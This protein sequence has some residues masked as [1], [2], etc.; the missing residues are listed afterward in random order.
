MRT[1]AARSV[2]FVVIALGLGFLLIGIVGVVVLRTTG[3]G[4][5]GLSGATNRLEDWIGSQVVGIANSYL[6]PQIGYDALN[7]QA[8]GTVVLTGVTFTAPDGTEVL[9]LGV[10]TVTLAEVPRIGEPIHIERLMLD[11]PTIRLIR[12]VGDDGE[13]GLRGLNPI[14]KA[15]GDETTG[16]AAIEDNFKLS[17]VLRLQQIDL[18]E[19]AL[20]YDQGDGSPPMTISGL[21]TT[22]HAHA[23]ETL[24]G[25]YVLDVESALGP[26]AAMTL[27]GLVSLDTF[28]ARINEFTLS[29]HLS[30]ESLGILP[31]QL[32]TL[33][34][35]YEV[36]GQL[37]L[38][39]SGEV[40]LTDSLIAV[41]E[42]S[43]DLEDFR[44]A[45]GEYQ[46]PIQS[47]RAEASLA[48]GVATLSKL[49]ATMLGGEVRL[50]GEV[51]LAETGM[52]ASA[53]WVI[54]DIELHD[55]LR[56]NTQTEGPPKLAGKL[57]AHGRLTT[58]LDDPRGALEGTGELHLRE[59][60]VMVLPGLTQLASVM[61]VIT[62]A[63][64][65]EEALNHMADAE[66]V[67]GPAG[68]EITSSE[69][70]TEFLVARGTGTIGFDGS[71][72]LTINGGP[73]E[74][75]QS[76]LGGL[77]DVIGSVTDRLVKYRIRGTV[78]APEVSVAPLGI[79]G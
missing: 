43:M 18:I 16:E 64:T 58:E 20:F 15:P 72:D 25:W 9:E 52:P 28:S 79:G 48:G 51:R 74:K 75:L 56:A 65:G 70:T 71:L 3:I 67:L 27:D 30:P 40:S 49:A 68:V 57:L 69:V 13:F 26:L 78:D 17:T 73:M 38:T 7:Y 63:K 5:G 54:D 55:L 2:K 53:F 59:G 23:D 21:T 45:S 44:V 39:A 37:D 10:L 24:D 76:M 62:T 31:P 32:Q 46:V 66:F 41:L 4:I 42:V 19:G 35:E 1:S 50:N 77:G 61:S 47:A 36:Q 12:E 29:G 60:R 14:L 34:Q 8:P 6:V 11:R 33:A 22:I